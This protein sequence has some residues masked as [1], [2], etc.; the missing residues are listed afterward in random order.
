[1]RDIMGAVKIKVKDFDLALTLDSGQLFRYEPHGDGFIV[2]SFDRFFALEQNRNTLILNHGS[3]EE[4]Q[5]FF[6]LDDDL[7]GVFATAPHHI[8]Q[9]FRALRGLRLTRQNPWECLVSFVLSASSSILTIKRR[10]ATLCRLY[11]K[12]VSVLGRTCHTFPE[13]GSLGSE[14]ELRQLGMGFRASYLDALNRTVDLAFLSELKKLNYEE[15][16]K[17][18]T[19]LPGVGSKVAD[20]VLLFSCEHLQAF[21]V[22]VWIKRA[23]RLFHFPS[24]ERLRSFAQQLYGPYAGYYQQYLYHWVRKKWKV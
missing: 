1:M 15:A 8:R 14:R 19:S 2:G 24:L 13:P 21:P 12:E 18:L 23:M 10:V 6:R 5:N 22:D 20:C 11:G 9:L 3:L 16:H 17:R 4:I 7:P